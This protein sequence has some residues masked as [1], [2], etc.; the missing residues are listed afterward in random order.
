MG[1]IIVALGVK[2]PRTLVRENP[3]NSEPLVSS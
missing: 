1:V 2:L 3:I